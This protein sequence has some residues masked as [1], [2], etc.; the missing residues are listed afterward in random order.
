MKKL[1]EDLPVIFIDKYEDLTT[2]YLMEQKKLLT[3]KQ[4][5]YNKLTFNYWK[6]FI[7]NIK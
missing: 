1:Y 6:T 2:E 5:N 3:S 4:F 7:E